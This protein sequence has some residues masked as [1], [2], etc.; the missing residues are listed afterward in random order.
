M[1]VAGSSDPRRLRHWRKVI[2]IPAVAALL[3]G[4]LISYFFAPKLTSQSLVLVQ[5]ARIPDAVVAQVF[6]EDLSQHILAIQQQVLSPSRLR[7][8]VERLGLAKPGQNIEDVMDSIRSNMTIEPVTT[9]LSGTQIDSPGKP[10][11]RPSAPAFYVSYTGSTAKEAHEICNELTSMLLE[12]DLKSRQDA[13]QGTTRF[14]T[15]EVE[16]AR[17]NLDDL[18]RK[19]APLKGQHIAPSLAVEFDNARKVYQDDLAKQSTVKMATQVEQTQLGE[20]MLLLS[21]ASLPD[22]ADFP[23]RLLFAGGGLGIGL[24]FGISLAL[25]LRYRPQ[26]PDSGKESA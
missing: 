25:W 20:Q 26:P 7:P 24:M 6:T 23:N 19:L 11:Q 2:L 16:E 14:L 4:F 3:A 13:S 5:A 9:D 12:E 22:S 1:E 18:D 8:M 21:P 15:A 17:Q 10:S